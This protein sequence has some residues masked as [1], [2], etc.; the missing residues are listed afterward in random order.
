MLVGN[1]WALRHWVGTNDD[2]EEEPQSMFN[3]KTPEWLGRFD[4]FVPGIR[5]QGLPH[6]RNRISRSDPCNEIKTMSGISHQKISTCV[7]A[8]LLDREGIESS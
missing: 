1:R 6:K 7:L 8:G 2:T 3:Q 5:I 4:T